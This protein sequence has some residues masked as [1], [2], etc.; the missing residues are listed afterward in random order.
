[1]SFDS[2]QLPAFMVIYIGLPTFPRPL[3]FFFLLSPFLFCRYFLTFLFFLSFFSLLPPGSR[4]AI[5]ANP[6]RQIKMP[7]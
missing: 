3:F 6:F 2:F 1:M 7:S 4:L 5:Y